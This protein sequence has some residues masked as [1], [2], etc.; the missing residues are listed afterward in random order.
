MTG[1]KLQ[2]NKRKLRGFSGNQ[3]K[4]IAF[5]LMLCDHVGFMLIEN[6]MLYGQNPVYW[7]MAINSD[8]G[9]K[10]YLIAR[11]LRLV[12]RLSFPIF[13]FFVAEGFSHT[14]N[15]NRYIARMGLFAVFS[16]V[17]FDLACYGK[18]YYPDYQNVLFTYFIALIAL[19]FM[20]R[21]KKKY[22]LQVLVGALFAGAAYLCRTDYDAFGVGFICL[23]WMLRNSP[24]AR[25]I[26]GALAGAA[27]SM[28]FYGASAVS[29]ILL[30]FYNGQRGHVPLKY[31]FYFMYPLHLAVFYLLVYLPNR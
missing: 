22:V 8:E 3:L 2:F 24:K 26:T 15:E 14:S 18:Y 12:G 13:A 16:E 19:K 6:G 10:L 23:M 30:K 7:N 5:F 29:F 25:I 21:L 27:E 20:H 11:I 4:M 9:R 17:P 31:F 28:E 1:K